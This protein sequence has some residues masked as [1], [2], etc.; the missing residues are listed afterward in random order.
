MSMSTHSETRFYTC[1]VCGGVIYQSRIS[2]GT[3]YNP[4]RTDHLVH[5]DVKD[6]QDNVHQAVIA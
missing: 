1:K 3:P 6:W 5:L 2:G 4:E